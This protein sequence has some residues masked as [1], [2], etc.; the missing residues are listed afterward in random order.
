MQFHTIDLVILGLYI[1]AT[2]W[3]GFYVA[4]LAK[5]NIKHYFLGGNKIPWYFL[6]MSNASGM[7][8]ISGTMWLVYLLFIYGLKSIW[9]PWLWPVFNQIFLMVFLSIWLR[10]SGVMTGAEWIKF[11]FGDDR[12]AHMAHVIVVVFAILNVIGFI[13]Y[14]F[15]GIG[16]FAAA[17]LPWQLMADPAANAYAYGLIITAITT[18]Y[19]VKGGMFSVVFTEVLQYAIM[20][21]ASIWVGIIAMNKVSPGT[22]DALVPEGW[23][24]PFFGWKLDLDWSGIMETANLK[25]AEDGWTIFGFFFMMMLFKGWLQAGAG[26]APNYDMQRILAARKP[27]EAAKMS[28][29]VS[30]VLNIPRYMLV[31]G[32][33]VLAIA[34]FSDQLNAMGADVDFELILPFALANFIPVGLLG[35]L[36]AA[37]LAAFMSTYAATV[38]AAPAYIVN[39]IYKRFINPNAPA[40]V[41]VRWSYAISLI[42]VVLGTA[43]GFIL[44]TIHDIVQWIVAAL[45]GGY[46]AAN[47][48]KWYW[49]RFNSYG[50]FWGMVAGIIGSMIFPAVY[51]DVPVIYVFPLILLVSLIGCIVGTLLTPPDDEKVLKRFYI[52]VRPWGFWKPIHEKVVAEYPDLQRNNDFKRD[53]VNVVVGI[54]WQTALVASG[55]FL[56]IQQF[57][58]LLICI[59]IILA[60]SVFLKYNWYDKMKD[61]PDKYSEE[62]EPLPDADEDTVPEA[63][64]EPVTENMQNK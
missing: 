5:K 35:L 54:A 31:T 56:V 8:D 4:H 33:T 7:Y 50:Y 52:K 38:N 21:I 27:T 44:G 3:I 59:V 34:F 9:I 15:V 47:V 51:A 64:A 57:D 62:L 10:R 46:T 36:T 49:W 32:L 17:F 63:A 41:Y 16:K 23:R 11:R 6:G 1:L 43:F 58:A 25:I 14:G 24:N 61:Y 29:L 28:G 13:A 19:V 22:L 40:R 60:S 12:G 30:L 39:D 42:V 18:V 53:M 20:T 45:Y 48:L 55:I 37:L 2:I 26:P